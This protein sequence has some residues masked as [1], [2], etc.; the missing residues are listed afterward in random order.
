MDD[1]FVHEVIQAVR[2]PVKVEIDGK[3]MPF[4]KDLAFRVKDP[5]VAA[6]IRDKYGGEKGDVTVTRVKYPHISDRGHNYHFTVPELPWHKEQEHA[7]QTKR[8]DST[9]EEERALGDVED[10][11]VREESDKPPDSVE[12]FSRTQEQ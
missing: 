9:G 3:R 10:T 7:V 4:G 6:A 12:Y 8:N 11:P 5:G 2:R 1:G